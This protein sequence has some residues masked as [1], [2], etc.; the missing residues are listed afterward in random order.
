MWLV[1]LALPKRPDDGGTDGV[2][3]NDGGNDSDGVG[4]NDIAGN[5]GLLLTVGAGGVAAKGSSMAS[6]GSTKRREGARA[7]NVPDGT[8]DARNSVG[9]G[10]DNENV[11]DGTGA[12][13]ASSFTEGARGS[14]NGSTCSRTGSSGAADGGNGGNGGDDDDDDDGAVTNGDKNDDEGSRDDGPDDSGGKN[15]GGKNDDDGAGG[16]EVGDG[17][18]G[19]GDVIAGG[20]DVIAGGV[21]VSSRVVDVIVGVDAGD[22]VIAGAGW[23]GGKSGAGI[24]SGNGVRLVVIGMRRLANGFIG[25]G[26]G[27]GTGPSSRRSMVRSGSMRTTSARRV[28]AVLPRASMM[29][30]M[31][32]RAA[33]ARVG[34]TTRAPRPRVACHWARMAASSGHSTRPLGCKSGKSP[35]ARTILVDMPKATKHLY[36]QASVGCR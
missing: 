27:M 30:S 1:S 4:A 35:M 5:A 2:D 9:V 21:D 33:R 19:V 28:I 20:G 14:S 25:G 10:G 13:M 11:D 34:R 18:A 8:D 7:S 29:T 17:S 12:E 24:S 31:T 32:S 15:D 26:G 36:W 22:G 3:D 23:R 16:N 6:G